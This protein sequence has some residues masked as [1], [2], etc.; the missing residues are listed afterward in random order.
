MA[1][2]QRLGWARAAGCLPGQAAGWLHAGAW[3]EHGVGRPAAELCW[4]ARPLLARLCE[5]WQGKPAV[6]VKFDASLEVGSCVLRT[7]TG[8]TCF[9]IGWAQRGTLAMKTRCELC[10]KVSRMRAR[11]AHCEYWKASSAAP[12]GPREASG[13]LW[14]ASWA[15]KPASAAC[16]VEGVPGLDSGS[17]RSDSSACSP[18][19]AHH[20][21]AQCRAGDGLAA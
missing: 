6:H 18:A 21:H 2:Q 20:R 5:G 15:V 11:V 7:A 12:P 19:S 4:Q 16:L 1:L 8:H 10:N 13:C 17:D 9:D 14:A 3:T